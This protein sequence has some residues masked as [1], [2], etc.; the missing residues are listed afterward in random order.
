MNA[1]NKAKIEGLDLYCVSF[2]VTIVRVDICFSNIKEKS[3]S[4]VILKS[5]LSL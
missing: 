4:H 2:G 5:N 1:L 3:D